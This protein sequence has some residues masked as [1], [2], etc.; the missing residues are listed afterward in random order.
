VIISESLTIYDEIIRHVTVIGVLTTAGL[1]L[2][3]FKIH[4][5]IKDYVN[6]LWKEYCDKHGIV[7]IPVDKK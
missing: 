2:R 7:Y 4:N 5:R 3:E 6:S 1:L